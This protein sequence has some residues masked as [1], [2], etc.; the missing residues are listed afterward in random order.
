MKFVLALCF[1]VLGTA[2][3]KSPT[4]QRFCWKPATSKLTGGVATGFNGTYAL[5]KCTA[6]N[7]HCARIKYVKVGTTTKSPTP[8]SDKGHTKAPTVS[9]KAPTASKAPTKKPTYAPT[10]TK[11]P[12]YAPREKQGKAEGIYSGCAGQYNDMNAYLPFKVSAKGIT[13]TTSDP[14]NLWTAGN[15]CEMVATQY[16]HVPNKTIPETGDICG[17]IYWTASQKYTLC[18]ARDGNGVCTTWR[19]H[20]LNQRY[21]AIVVCSLDSEGTQADFDAEKGRNG[22]WT[23]TDWKE[24]PNGATVQVHFAAAPK[25]TPASALAVFLLAATGGLL[26]QW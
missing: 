2:A 8:W 15:P 14:S 5:Q 4:R 12:T 6:A 17:E 13:S 11:N 18:E 20:F 24:C 26:S 19:E 22:N 9:T 7:D 23:D 3:T 16:L 25:A 10:K 21:K 1:L